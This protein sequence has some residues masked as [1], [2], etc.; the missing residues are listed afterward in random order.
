MIKHNTIHYEKCPICEAEWL[1]V[2]EWE[3]W[4]E[5]AT[6]QNYSKYKKDCYKECICSNCSYAKNSHWI[7]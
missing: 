1:R 3:E 4:K 5:L 2:E 7:G 6:V